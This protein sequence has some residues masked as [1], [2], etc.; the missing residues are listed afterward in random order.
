MLDWRMARPKLWLRALRYVVFSSFEVEK[1]VV[2]S[3]LSLT[4][5][6]RIK[7]SKEFLVFDLA[8]G[9]LQMEELVSSLLVSYRLLDLLKMY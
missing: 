7:T 6:I 5:T 2:T 1:I 4:S 8:V 3:R 9:D